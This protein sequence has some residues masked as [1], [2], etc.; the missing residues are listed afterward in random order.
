MPKRG[1]TGPTPKLKNNKAATTFNSED[2]DFSKVDRL[3]TGYENDL[4]ASTTSLGLSDSILEVKALPAKNVIGRIE[5][6]I[7]GAIRSVITQKGLDYL[8]PSRSISNQMYIPELDRNVRKNDKM[9]TRSFVNASMVHKT[10]ITTKIFQLVHNILQR[11]IHITKRDMFYTDVK[12]F[13]DQKNSDAV[14]DDVACMIGCSRTTLNVVA[15]EKGV[16]VGRLKYREDGDLIDCSKMGIGG[17]GIP[18]ILDRV[19]DIESDAKL[20]CL[21]KRTLLSFVSQRTGFIKS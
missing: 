2:L 4:Q 17:K 9:T 5:E 15:S 14:L 10:T 8:I 11:G 6:I 7:L 1:K 18:P 13:V 19:T 3:R 12:L 16:V 20:S 21:L